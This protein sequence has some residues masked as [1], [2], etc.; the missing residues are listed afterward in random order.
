MSVAALRRLESEF[1]A[2]RSHADGAIDLEELRR[3]RANDPVGFNRDVLRGDPRPWQCEI[4]EAVLKHPRVAVRSCNGAGKDWTAA[5]L[6]VWAASMGWLVLITGPTERQVKTV[7]MGEAFRAWSVAKLPGEFYE[8]AWRLDRS[9]TSGILA[10][11]SN[12]ISKLTGLHAPKLLAI[13][14]EAQGV[15]SHVF[16]AMHANL[17]G[18]VSR[19]LIVGNPLSPS[20]AFFE[21]CRS[22]NWHHIHI[23]AAE[24]IPGKLP[25]G[26][27]EQFVETMAGEYGVGSGIYRARVLGEF[28]EESD[29]ALCRRAWVEAAFERQLELDTSSPVVLALDVARF[30][31]DRNC[32]AIRQGSV[33]RE[34]VEWGNTDLMQTVDRLRTEAHRFGVR[35]G[36]VA[37]NG[38]GAHPSRGLVVVDSIGMGGGVLDRLRELGY[39]TRSFVGGERSRRNGFFNSRALAYWIVRE[40]LE[41]ER[42][43]LPPN[44]K[45]ADEL[46]AIRWRESPSGK[47]V[48]LE[49]KEVLAERLGRSPDTADALSMVLWARAPEYVRPLHYSS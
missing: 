32:L 39:E 35:P 13:I 31:P 29:E 42:L 26:I 46:C 8:L 19:L 40:E 12:D 23:G 17:T 45:L 27:T 11:T 1:G 22:P 4:A 21:A 37:A 24:A 20:G 38:F 2:L 5:R 14:T 15:P 25:G 41:A 6:A 48:M 10:F 3:Q 43:A 34:F 16:E 49:R 9:D 44:D 30:G 47:G 33:V 18:D 7:V 28:P 36:R